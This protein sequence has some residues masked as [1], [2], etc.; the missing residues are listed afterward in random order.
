MASKDIILPSLVII[1]VIMAGVLTYQ[2]KMTNTNN[3]LVAIIA[4]SVVFIALANM[5]TRNEGFATE[6]DAE[7]IEL[8]SP[9]YDS[10]E[11]DT[12]KPPVLSSNQ[13]DENDNDDNDV[14]DDVYGQNDL[15]VDGENDD[16]TNQNNEMFQHKLLNEE[17]EI[18]DSFNNIE[19][20][21]TDKNR[22]ADILIEQS[23]MT[24]TG[25]IF[26]PQIIIQDNNE[27]TKYRNQID[28]NNRMQ[29]PKKSIWTAD[30]GS[31]ENNRN[32]NSNNSNNSNNNSNNSNS[33]SN[34][35]SQDPWDVSQDFAKMTYYKQLKRQNKGRP[36]LPFN[37]DSEYIN[38]DND[39]DLFSNKCK[40]SSKKFYPG[41]SIIPPDKWDVPQKRPKHCIPD[42]WKRPSGVF[43]AGTPVNVLE[44][45]NNGNML[46]DENEVTFT[47]VGSILPKFTYTEK[48]KY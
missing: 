35:D 21:N 39:M 47:N 41:Y 2:R 3:I 11:E 17:T 44:L 27:N 22:R 6:D 36:Q 26:T 32:C 29:K 12:F 10:E 37:E 5:K 13:I 7:V 18:R 16:Y 40:T 14:D 9:S 20:G 33:N 48:Y 25:N 28:H 4:L 30:N 24:G 42:K 19:T 38:T 8:V 45:D 34:E 46:L 1:L 23:G 31:F 43:T 15:D